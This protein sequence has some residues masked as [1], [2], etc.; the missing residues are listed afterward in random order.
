MKRHLSLTLVML[1][2]FLLPAVSAQ[3]QMLKATIP[4]D[5]SVGQATLPAGD[6]VV[7]KPGNSQN[8]LVIRAENGGGNAFAMTGSVTSAST[9]DN[10]KLVFN[11]YGSQY[12]LSQV[13]AA[14]SDSGHQLRP[15]KAEREI[16]KNASKP[17]VEILTASK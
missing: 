4:F 6:Y 12:F 16:A 8:V 15:S 5:F 1:A 11:R 7:S 13:W 17:K 10:G 2:A 14:G 9:N 3:A